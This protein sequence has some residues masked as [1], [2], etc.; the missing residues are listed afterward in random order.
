MGELRTLRDKQ[1]AINLQLNELTGV[2]SR[3][4]DM[5]SR[6]NDLET[7]NLKKQQKNM[8]SGREDAWESL[9]EISG[10]FSDTYRKIR[11]IDSELLKIQVEY[12]KKQMEKTEVGITLQNIGEIWKYQ[13]AEYTYYV[14]LV[15]AIR[16]LLVPEKTRYK[17][18]L[19]T[20]IKWDKTVYNK[21][22]LITPDNMK[23]WIDELSKNLQ[24]LLLKLLEE[25]TD[26]TKLIT[27]SDDEKELIEGISLL[28]GILAPEEQ[29]KFLEMSM[30]KNIKDVIDSR[31]K[32]LDDNRIANELTASE[33]KR[34]IE[35][36]ILRLERPEDSSETEPEKPIIRPIFRKPE[37]VRRDLMET[38]G[39]RIEE[40]VRR[41]LMETKGLRI[42]EPKR[43]IEEHVRRE[44]L[45]VEEPKMVKYLPRRL[46]ERPSED[47]FD[48]R[49]YEKGERLK[50]EGIVEEDFRRAKDRLPLIVIERT[51]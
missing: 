8:E 12:K 50:E 34:S 3:V 20:F 22:S 10:N 41:D 5:L 4:K 17:E 48:I 32:L 44:G 43:G 46:R 23:K 42:E 47:T 31:M 19:K 36:P 35:R 11:Q 13:L 2:L 18:G 1:M 38:K 33:I 49:K 25:K 45:R 6:L 51:K 15:E 40:P 16:Y 29:Y 24:P 37:P 7:E 26:L 30:V 9:K 27:Y 14:L 39:L 21:D 28:K